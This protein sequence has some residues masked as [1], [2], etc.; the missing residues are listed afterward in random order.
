[1]TFKNLDTNTSWHL[2]AYENGW[3]YVCKLVNGLMNVKVVGPN[4]EL[5]HEFN[6][7]G[8]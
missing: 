6:L 5:V 7:P 8:K 1:M 3:A 4:D 2:T